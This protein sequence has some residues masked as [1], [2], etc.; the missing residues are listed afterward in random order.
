MQ[1]TSAAL[2]VLTFALFVAP[3]INVATAEDQPPAAKASAAAQGEEPIY[4]WQLMTPEERAEHRAKMRSLKT[5]KE[6][7]EYRA[8]HHKKMEER[9]KAMGKTI[10]EEPPRRAPP[11]MPPPMG[12]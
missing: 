11:R 9:A 2:N 12:Y 4:G 7:D 1:K 10:P 3:C 8:E 5:E 6:R